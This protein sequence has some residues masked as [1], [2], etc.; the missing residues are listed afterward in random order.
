MAFP[1]CKRT[2]FREGERPTEGRVPP[3]RL[4]DGYGVLA[5]LLCFLG[6]PLSWALSL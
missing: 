3:D 1:C 2:A 6:L 4:Q 5:A